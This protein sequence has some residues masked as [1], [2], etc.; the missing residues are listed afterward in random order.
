MLNLDTR[1]GT[2]GLGAGSCLPNTP[3]ALAYILHFI[4]QHLLKYTSRRELSLDNNLR[5]AR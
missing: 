3:P 1:T 2:E 5:G 4:N